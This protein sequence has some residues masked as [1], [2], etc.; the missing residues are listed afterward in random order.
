MYGAYEK[1]DELAEGVHFQ[2]EDDGMLPTAAATAAITTKR[3]RGHGRHALGGK[4]QRH[5]HRKGRIFRPLLSFGPSI[6][7][8]GTLFR[9]A[10]AA[11][12]P[13]DNGF[14]AC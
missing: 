3:R 14:H 8:A 10:G 7:L 13:F 5:N 11:A 12:S 1:V 2:L 9:R 4:R 6:A